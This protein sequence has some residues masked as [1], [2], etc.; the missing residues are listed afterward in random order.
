MALQ[1][2]GIA[3]MRVIRPAAVVPERAARQ[4]MEWLEDN[5][6]TR[7]GCWLH[8]T[9]CV[10]RFSGPFDGPSGMRG[11]AVLL[12]SIHMVWERF[13]AT[14]YRANITEAGA[15]QGLT[16]ERLC[17]HVLGQVGL[18]LETCPRAELVDAPVPDPFRQIPRARPAFDVGA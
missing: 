13:T 14:I 9:S 10:Q 6:V 16:V 12:G 18:S 7:G 3:Q 2:R 17:D 5:D 15:G 11:S 8:D 1:S 4:I